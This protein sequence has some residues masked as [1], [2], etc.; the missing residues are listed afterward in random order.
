MIRIRPARLQDFEEITKM[1]KE[2]I[3]TVYKG[4]HIKE[5]IFFYGIVQG[6]YQNNK[7]IMT[8]YE[9][10]TEKITGFSLSYV[11]DVG[12]TPP[13]V[14]GELAYIKPE[15][16]KGKSAYKL[17]HHVVEL[18][19]NMKMN[20]VSSGYVG[21]GAEDKIEQIMSRFGEPFLLEMRRLNKG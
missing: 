13:Y 17:Y 19:D 18:A 12:F 6:W 2:L 9:D 16:R 11:E 5:D 15:F 14:K 4:F 21:D 7:T 20:L 8:S 3:K 10:E 1:Y